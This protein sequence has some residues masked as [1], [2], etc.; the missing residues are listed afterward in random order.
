MNIV[1]SYPLKIAQQK[2]K[3]QGSNT[4]PSIST[5]THQ[6]IK[7]SHVSCHSHVQDTLQAKI[8]TIRPHKIKQLK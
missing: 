7:L 8:C 2:K 3:K 5:Q 4:L 6:T 1:P